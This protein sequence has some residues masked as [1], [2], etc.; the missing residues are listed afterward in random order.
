M[1]LE[2]LNFANNSISTF[3]SVL[4]HELPVKN[5]ENC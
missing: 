3:I 2:F 4:G 1:A 5:V